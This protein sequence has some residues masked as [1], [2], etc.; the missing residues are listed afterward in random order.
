M[1]DLQPIAYYKAMKTSP[2]DFPIEV[3]EKVSSTNDTIL[4]A[5]EE[6]AVEGTTHVARTQTRGRG[7]EQRPW[8]SPRGAGLWMSTLL[9]PGGRR[10][11][12]SGLALISGVAVV[13]TLTR[14]GVRDVELHWPNDVMVHGRKLGG[15]LCEVRGQGEQAWIALGIGLNIDLTSGSAHETMPAELRDR[16]TCMTAE[17]P[18]AER[19]PR[20]IAR[21][22]LEEFWPLYQRFLNDVKTADLVGAHLGAAGRRVEVQQV[23]GTVLRGTVVGLGPDGELR[24]RDSAGRVTSVIAGEVRHET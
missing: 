17:G 6:G 19:D 23:E 13:E 24:V 4:K 20:A 21:T 1:A 3:H 11:A 14:L 15:I 5:G 8:W 9:R 12:W 7:R 18:P 10:S 22:I 16:I 2:G